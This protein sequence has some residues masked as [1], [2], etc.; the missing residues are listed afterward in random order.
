[1][2]YMDMLRLI[3]LEVKREN[4]GLTLG[5]KILRTLIHWQ[6]GC[7]HMHYKSILFARN[8]KIKVLGPLKMSNYH[9]Y[10]IDEF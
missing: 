3:F 5:I 8:L 10:R 4:K 9:V 1:M 7:V 2:L 6:S